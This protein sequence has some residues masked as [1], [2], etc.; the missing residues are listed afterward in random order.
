MVRNKN[1]ENNEKPQENEEG[2]ESQ[3]TP[4][5]KPEIITKALRKKGE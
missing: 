5:A 1:D 3:E 4:L 2:T